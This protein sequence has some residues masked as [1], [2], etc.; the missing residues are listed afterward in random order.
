MTRTGMIIELKVHGPS[1]ETCELYLNSS[2]YVNRC[3]SDLCSAWCATLEKPEKQ[4]KVKEK[5]LE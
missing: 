1:G 3:R 2:D 5:E 4:E